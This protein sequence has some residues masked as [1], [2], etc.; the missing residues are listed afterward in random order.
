MGS[1]ED[2]QSETGRRTFNAIAAGR[3]RRGPVCEH[4]AVKHMQI[5]FTQLSEESS[6]SHYF[7]EIYLY[8]CY[9]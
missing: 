5:S 7:I 4:L 9:R 2:S 1:T 3:Y 8:R 6:F